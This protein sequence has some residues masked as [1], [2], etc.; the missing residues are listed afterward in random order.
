[1]TIGGKASQ[2]IVHGRN[3]RQQIRFLD[4]GQKFDEHLLFGGCVGSQ[5]FGFA[6]GFWIRRAAPSSVGPHGISERKL[7]ILGGCGLSGLHG[8]VKEMVF[9]LVDGQFD[10]FLSFRRFGRD[11]K[12]KHVSESR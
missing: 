10:E 4:G 8:L 2:Q 1:M 3:S 6:R 5:R 9:V 11:G 7:R 12:G